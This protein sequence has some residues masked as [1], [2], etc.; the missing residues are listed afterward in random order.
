MKEISYQMALY[1]FNKEVH[2]VYRL[3]DDGTESL[4]TSNNE[5][6]IHN[7]QHGIFGIED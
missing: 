5:I 2:E 4:I 1:L 6:H 7:S 3:Y